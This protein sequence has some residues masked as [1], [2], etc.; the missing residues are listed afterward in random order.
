MGNQESSTKEVQT[1][2]W[3]SEKVQTMIYKTPHRTLKI[4]QHGLN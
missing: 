4:E 1:I 3:P 2:Q